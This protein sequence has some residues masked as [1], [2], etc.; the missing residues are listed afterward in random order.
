MSHKQSTTKD[1]IEIVME[2]LNSKDKDI[3]KNNSFTANDRPNFIKRMKIWLKEELRTLAKNYCFIVIITIYFLVSLRAY[4][5]TLESVWYFF[6]LYMKDITYELAKISLL[7]FYIVRIFI[8]LFVEILVLF[9]KAVNCSFYSIVI[10]L[11][12]YFYDICAESCAS[13]FGAAI[14]TVDLTYITSSY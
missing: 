9:A 3:E 1:D 10:H 14:D 13:C 7:V 11:N 4:G 8:V 2:D 12:L 5:I 6:S